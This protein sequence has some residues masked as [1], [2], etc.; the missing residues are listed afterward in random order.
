MKTKYYV[1][2]KNTEDG[3]FFDIQ[4]KW[5]N[6][7]QQA[8]KWYIDSFDFIRR[9]TTIV[10]LMSAN[11]DDDGEYDDIVFVEELKPENFVNKENHI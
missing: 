3:W 9:A 10:S 11:F 5:F 7:K 6:T 2:F 1:E 4:S 8:I